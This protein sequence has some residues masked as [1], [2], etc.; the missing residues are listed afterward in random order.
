MKNINNFILRKVDLSVDDVDYHPNIPNLF[1]KINNIG[2]GRIII[3]KKR[4][5][6]AGQYP[7]NYSVSNEYKSNPIISQK[8]SLKNKK[9]QQKIKEDSEELEKELKKDIKDLEKEMKQTNDNSKES[10]EKIQDD[11]KEEI[12]DVEEKMEKL[13]DN[14]GKELEDNI[15]DVKKDVTSEL[16]DLKNKFERRI[17][18]LEDRINENKEKL[19]NKTDVERIIRDIKN[20]YEAQINRIKKE[21][22][23]VIRDDRKRKKS[24]RESKYDEDAEEKALQE[25]MEKADLI[26]KRLNE[27]ER[28]RKE[29][30][31]KDEIERKK[32][33]ELRKKR[34]EKI[35]KRLNKAKSTPGLQNFCSE[36]KNEKNCVNDR[37]CRYF[38]DQVGCITLKESNILKLKERRE[39]MERKEKKLSSQKTYE[40]DPFTY[41]EDREDDFDPFSESELAKISQG[42]QNFCREY[43][44]ERNCI[45]DKRC[46]YSNNKCINKAKK[47]WKKLA[48]VRRANKEIDDRGLLYL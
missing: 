35:K 48:N 20:D 45:N 4:D 23:Q 24:E 6:W 21:K 16:E 40:E 34:M 36:Y 18:S 43:V 37:K 1:T 10:V 13:L 28:Q 30:Q 32:N 11:L 46:S 15:D 17:D 44:N 27:L 39:Q 12:D 38:N 42:L 29:K 14:T 19:A 9:I 25:D 2:G 8:S 3:Q 31:E 41:P 5:S 22:K 26:F 33:R 7:A 47:K